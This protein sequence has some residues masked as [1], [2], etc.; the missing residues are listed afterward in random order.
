[1]IEQA[2]F[3]LLS[4]DAD[5]SAVIGT[6]IFPDII[7]QQ[8]FNEAT[9]NPC[10]TYTM[11]GIDRQKTTCGTDAHVRGALAIDCYAKNKKLVK[12][13]SKL[14]RDALLDQR[15]LFPIDGSSPPAGTVFISQVSLDSEFDLVD[16]EP[17]LFRV[18]LGF[19]VWHTEER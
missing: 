7:P 11:Q 13:V 10:L 15:G 9:K 6:R 3:Q 4:S 8:A 12:S 14:V 19:S 5:L 2:L 16:I 17:G 1:M 18:S